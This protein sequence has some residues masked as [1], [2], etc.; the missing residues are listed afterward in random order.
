MACRERTRTSLRLSLSIT[1][2][3]RA[4]KIV[5]DAVGNRAQRSHRAGNHD[6][7]VHR[8]T[9][10]TRSKRR[11]LCL[12]EFRSSRRGAAKN[13]AR[14]LLQIAGRNAQL[15]RR[16]A[17]ARF[18]NHQVHPRHARIFLEQCQHFLRENRPAGPGH[19]Y[20]NDLFLRLSHVFRADR[21][22]LAAALRASQ[23]KVV[24]RVQ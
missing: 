13:P 1:S 16:K 9:A 24:V 20:G 5:A 2:A 12:A 10:R 17:L 15:F 6:H 19:T 4:T 21:F 8:V 22:S 14:Q 11:H 3:A 18:R 23:A 7:R